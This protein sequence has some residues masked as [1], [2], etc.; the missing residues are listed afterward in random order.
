MGRKIAKKCPKNHI[1]FKSAVKMSNFF[2]QNDEIGLNPRRNGVVATSHKKERGRV[3]DPPRK[4]RDK[5]FF[6]KCEQ[7]F[8]F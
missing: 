1:F 2:V 4:Q 5:N 3:K 8:D 7:T 6:K